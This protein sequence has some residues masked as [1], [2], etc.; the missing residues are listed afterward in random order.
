MDPVGHESMPGMSPSSTLPTHADLFTVEN[1]RSWIYGT[2][3]VFV[4]VLCVPAPRTG[5]AR[6][7][8]GYEL[9]SMP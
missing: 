6:V 8:G 2:V 9:F 4:L 5:G 3:T 1:A 7:L